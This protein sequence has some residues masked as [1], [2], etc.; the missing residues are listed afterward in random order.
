L[1]HWAAERWPAAAEQ[2]QLEIFARIN[3][4]FQRGDF[5]GDGRPDIAILVQH[6]VNRKVGLLILHRSGRRSLLGAGQ[7]FA[8]GGDD[9]DWVDL[10][11]VEDRGTLQRGHYDPTVRLQVDGLLLATEGSASGLI[12]F[13]K[14][15]F[16][17]Q[18]QGD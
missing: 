14:G 17:W 9:F 4:F 18:Q 13:S 15:R 10:W 16:R 2:L 6:K 8:N 11:W 12:Y 5:D 3:P 7:Q 1:P